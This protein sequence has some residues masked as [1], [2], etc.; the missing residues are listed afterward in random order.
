ME[1]W[2]SRPAIAQRRTARAA[3]ARARVTKEAKALEAKALEKMARARLA[4]VKTRA[5]RRDA[6]HVV[7]R[8]LLGSVLR[9]DGNKVERK[10]ER[11]DRRDIFVD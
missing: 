7:A 8:A 2:G 4:K 1:A 9:T 5:P 10:V 11:R 3:K 6:G